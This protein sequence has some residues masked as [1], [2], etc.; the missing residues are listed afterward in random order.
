MMQVIGKTKGLGQDDISGL[1][2]QRYPSQTIWSLATSFLLMD[3]DKD[4]RDCVR[5]D[6]RV[7]MY[8]Q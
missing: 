4:F 6:S 8:I 2:M 7:Q 3:Y 5:F 1:Y